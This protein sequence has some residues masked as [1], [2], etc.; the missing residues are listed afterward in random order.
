VGRTFLSAKASV[1]RTP[2][3]AKQCHP[4][5]REMSHSDISRSRRIPTEAGPALLRLSHQRSGCPSLRVFEGWAFV[6]P[7]P[8]DFSHSHRRPLASGAAET[9]GHFPVS[10]AHDVGI[11]GAHLSKPRKVGQ[12]I[13]Y[14]FRQFQAWA[15]P[16]KRGCSSVS[17][18]QIEIGDTIHLRI[19]K[20]NAYIQTAKGKEQRLDELSESV[21]SD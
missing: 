12:P 2:P 4:E 9:V 10:K 14:W 6:L 19:E 21:K 20:R 1:E 11:R 3:S 5:R 18:K 16:P 17:K 7:A 15:S 13:S 8:G